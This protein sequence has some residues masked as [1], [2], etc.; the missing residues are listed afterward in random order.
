MT[1]AAHPAGRRSIL[2]IVED[3]L[4]VVVSVCGALFV[5]IRIGAV[6]GFN[7]ETAFVILQSQ[8]TTSILL[9]TLLPSLIGVPLLVAVFLMF[10]LASEIDFRKLTPE[11]RHSF[12]KRLL[13]IVGIYSLGFLFMPWP[14]VLL[15]A[16]TVGFFVIVVKFGKRRRLRA[17]AAES[18]AAK[19]SRRRVHDAK[20]AR[21]LV[22]FPLVLSTLTMVGTA[23]SRGPW[24]PAETISV[25]GGSQVT[26]YVLS[27][28]DTTLI[29]MHDD[30]RIVLRYPAQES[31][32]KFCTV[33]ETGASGR[34][35][36]FFVLS[37]SVL[38]LFSNDANYPECPKN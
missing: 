33:Q 10:R 34:V 25:A 18:T 28:S 1:T 36:R 24:L 14:Q 17:A 26:G 19:R 7:Q 22:I 12:R 3:H 20:S 15:M 2:R 16:V 32:R 30:P 27:E 5:V 11:N 4:G 31:D 9:G 35:T 23:L 6:S 38:G 21:G 29:V 8:S 13:G 37:E